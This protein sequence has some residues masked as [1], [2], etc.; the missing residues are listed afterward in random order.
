[1]FRLEDTI[2]ANLCHPI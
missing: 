1:M 2:V